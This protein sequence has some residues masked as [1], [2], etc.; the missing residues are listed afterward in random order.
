MDTFHAWIYLCSCKLLTDFP[1]D[2]CFLTRTNVFANEFDDA[3]ENVLSDEF[4]L[5]VGKGCTR[6]PR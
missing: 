4:C 2:V 6:L 3:F 1:E 5:V